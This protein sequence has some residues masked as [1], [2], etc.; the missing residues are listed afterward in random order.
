M[1]SNTASTP[2]VPASHAREYPLQIQEYPY[3]WEVVFYGK[4]GFAQHVVFADTDVAAYRLAHEVAR[5]YGYHGQ[6]LVQGGRGD[7]LVDLDKLI[8]KPG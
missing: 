4:N 7:H 1:A 6:A 8:Q 5:L 2:L 3:G